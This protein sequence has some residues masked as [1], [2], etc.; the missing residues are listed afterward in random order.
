MPEILAYKNINSKVIKE[1]Y[2]MASVQRENGRFSTRSLYTNGELNGKGNVYLGSLD[3]DPQSIVNMPYLGVG[4]DNANSQGWLRD[5]KTFAKGLY[6]QKPE[7]FSTENLENMKKGRA[8]VVDERMAQAFPQYQG[9]EG[10]KLAHHHI[11]GDG[12]AVGVPES[13]H[14]GF[15]GV[16]NDF[17]CVYF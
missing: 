4:R 6:A 3:Y 17:I 12:Q 9:F 14:I 5:N 11:G 15:E 1:P 16:H 10:E 8:L 13:L 2:V 7:A